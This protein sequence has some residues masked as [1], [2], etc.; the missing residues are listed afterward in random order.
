[1]NKGT[2]NR[3]RGHNETELHNAEVAEVAEV[4]EDADVSKTR[5]HTMNIMRRNN[6]TQPSLNNI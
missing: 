1:M 6:D 4:A 3:P 2:Y 5:T